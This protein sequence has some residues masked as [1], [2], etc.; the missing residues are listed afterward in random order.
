V[1]EVAILDALT[2][3]FR[4]QFDDPTILLAPETSPRDIPAWDS[5]KTV[6]LVLAVEERFAITLKSREIDGLSSVGDWVRLLKSRC[7]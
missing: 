6:M 3:I 7:A 5:A 1:T 2:T 4:E